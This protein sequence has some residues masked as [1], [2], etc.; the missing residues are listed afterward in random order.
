[1]ISEERIGNN[2]EAPHTSICTWYICI[3]VLSFIMVMR[4]AA[5]IGYSDVCCCMCDE[6]VVFSVMIKERSWFIHSKN[7]E[8]SKS[9]YVM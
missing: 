4:T 2:V 3:A 5:V 9:D 6:A 1:M 7:L 8:F